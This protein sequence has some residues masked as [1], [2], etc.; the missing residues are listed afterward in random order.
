MEYVSATGCINHEQAARNSDGTYT[1]VISPTDAGV[2]NW[3]DTEHLNSGEMLIRWQALPHPPQDENPS[4]A[5]SRLVKLAQLGDVLP[6]N[7]RMADAQERRRQ[8]DQR[9]RAFARRI[10]QLRR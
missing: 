2:Y 6:P 8:I 5:K 3:V 9:E 7:T 4:I 10:G 1:L